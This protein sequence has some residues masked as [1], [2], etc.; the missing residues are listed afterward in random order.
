MCPARLS[1][2]GSFTAWRPNWQAECW[3]DLALVHKTSPHFAPLVTQLAALP[4]PFCH[5]LSTGWYPSWIDE[6]EPPRQVVC[7]RLSVAHPIQNGC[8]RLVGTQITDVPR[9]P[10]VRDA[11]LL[12]GSGGR[13]V[14]EVL[15]LE[16]GRAERGV[17]EHAHGH[18]LQQQ[19]QQQKRAPTKDA[20]DGDLPPCGDMPEE[21]LIPGR[22]E[23]LEAAPYKI[24]SWSEAGVFD[25]GTG[26][27]R[28][29]PVA[30][31][32]AQIAGLWSCK[33]SPPA[34]T[35]AWRPERCEL[36]DFD[37]S[38]V[39]GSGAFGS[40]ALFVGDSTMMQLF[41]A[42]V[43]G[44]GG[45]LNEIDEPMESSHQRTTASVCD[46]T[47]RLSFVRSELLLWTS[48]ELDGGHAFRKVG[49]ECFGTRNQPFAQQAARHAD[50]VV[51]GV[52]QHY[53]SMV[54][55]A[56][57]GG[58]ATSAQ[59]VSLFGSSLNHTLA[60]L[61]T[62]RRG[63]GRDSSRVLLVGASQPVRPCGVLAGPPMTSLVEAS[64]LPT[65]CLDA[66]EDADHVSA[67]ARPSS[68]S[69]ASSS[70]PS[71]DCHSRPSEMSIPNWMAASW[72]LVPRI[73]NLASLIASELD[74]RFVGLEVLSRL[75]GDA[76]IG[77]RH[78][79][80]QNATHMEAKTLLGEKRWMPL[81]DALRLDAPRSDDCVHS[82]MPG[83]VDSFAQLVFNALLSSM[84][85]RA[86]QRSTHG[87]G[88]L[89]PQAKQQ[90]LGEDRSTF[91]SRR[92][93]ATWHKSPGTVHEYLEGCADVT[94]AESSS[95]SA[96]VE[97]LQRFVP[98]LSSLRWWNE[99]LE[100]GR[101][102]ALCGA[103]K[104][105]YWQ[106]PPRTTTKV[107]ATAG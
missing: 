69:S 19:Q 76:L 70:S 23:L 91:F 74:V 5:R 21:K 34:Q 66:K 93:N 72:E 96:C 56:S 11:R 39:C 63:R 55:R 81:E 60:S 42:V 54:Q 30:T 38:S 95:R 48:S 67:T 106:R 107:K 36:R 51:I 43:L 102:R 86:S 57:L 41:L 18:H 68:A 87:H 7:P 26:T 47:V 88:E 2:C 25:F 24:P 80:K 40:S 61:I 9:R 22:W 15:R 62:A 103:L 27:Q 12:R 99:L 1:P 32:V 89:E 4:K 101:E 82:C 59:V 77:K 17:A 35:Y 79:R 8:L 65:A 33:P 14:A 98:K 28:H 49:V 75:R 6:D 44:L 53:A 10:K 85:K 3:Y 16:R 84:D 13:R 83:V 94:S 45:R 37:A 58:Q 100:E 29:Q 64:R 31:R 97:W 71:L 105:P 104:N 52:G 90:K 46:G 73:N 78:A 92:I 50:V 20:A